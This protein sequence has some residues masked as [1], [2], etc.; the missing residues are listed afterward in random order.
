M[1][2]PDG[3]V[4][5]GALPLNAELRQTPEPATA[6]LF[7]IGLALIAGWITARRNP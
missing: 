5:V 2:S 7:L 6:G 3:A 1:I 4:S